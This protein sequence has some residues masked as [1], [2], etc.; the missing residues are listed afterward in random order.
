MPKQDYKLEMTG[1][2]GGPPATISGGLAFGR[3]SIQE[4]VPVEAAVWL[5]LDQSWLKATSTSLVALSVAICKVW[6]S[7]PVQQL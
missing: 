3:R 7:G 5:E 6:Y 1:I 4:V 2:S